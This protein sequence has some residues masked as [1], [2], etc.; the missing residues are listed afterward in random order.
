MASG[1]WRTNPR[2]PFRNTP[3]LFLPPPPHLGP[4]LKASSQPFTS[5][6]MHSSH[7]LLPPLPSQ[8]APSENATCQSSSNA[9]LRSQSSSADL[10]ASN[11]HEGERRMVESLRRDAWEACSVARRGERETPGAGSRTEVRGVSHPPPPNKQLNRAGSRMK[12][13]N[14]LKS[15]RLHVVQRGVDWVNS[16]PLV[17]TLSN[18]S[19]SA[20]LTSVFNLTSRFSCEN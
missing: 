17:L 13:R 9:P 11:V 15:S 7:S 3:P 2:A 12:K 5:T 6:P 4:S 16:T 10:P 14:G 8:P 1:R 19:A 18:T 20:A